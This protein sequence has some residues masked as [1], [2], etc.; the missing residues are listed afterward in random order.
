MAS[1]NYSLSSFGLKFFRLLLLVVLFFFGHQAFASTRQVSATVTG[2]ATT[3]IIRF[4]TSAWPA[5]ASAQ[6]AFYS[7]H[8]GDTTTPY[9]ASGFSIFTHNYSSGPI[10]DAGNNCYDY[11]CASNWL[12]TGCYWQSVKGY[13]G[14]G[15]TGSLVVDVGYEFCVDSYTDEYT[16]VTFINSSDITS[17]TTWYNDSVYEVSGDIEI[18]SGNTLTVEPGVK[19]K[20]D[21]GSSLL[22]S[23][24]LDAQASVDSLIV[25]SS[26]TFSPSPG[27]WG[28]IKVSSGGTAIFDYVRLQDAGESG[29]SEAQIFNN[30]GTVSIDNSHIVYGDNYGILNSGGTTTIDNNTDIGFNNYGIYVNGGTLTVSNSVIHDNT[31]EGIHST[32]SGSPLDAEDNYWGDPS[33][34]SGVGAGSGDAVS[35]YVD[36]TPWSNVLH[37]PLGSNSVSNGKIQYNGTTYPYTAEF[38]SAVSTWNALSKI[39]IEPE[40]TTLD[41]QI[42]QNDYGD[43]G[44]AAEWVNDNAPDLMLLNTYYLSGAASSFVQNVITHELGHA[45]GLDHSYSGNIMYYISTTQT[46]LGAQDISDYNNL[47]P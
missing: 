25:L 43:L 27:T 44:W 37:Y 45:L 40:D 19:V 20:F 23:G 33:G 16:P 21:A 15:Y 17:N 38:T 3:Q 11:G 12:P 18:T 30:G 47:W 9:T 41:L 24:T 8:F 28:G 1:K 31:S 29:T 26:N 4:S 13:S 39:V 22:V 5:F 10:T 14:A 35:T 2:T 34:P 32:V 42:I 46:S 36:F 7:G 6:Y